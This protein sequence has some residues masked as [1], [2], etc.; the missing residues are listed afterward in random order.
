MPLGS[1]VVTGAGRLAHQALIHV[2]GFNPLWTA[3]GRSI[4]RSNR[5]AIAEAAQ[6]GFASIAVPA[7]GAG[8]ERLNT[9]RS[10][11]RIRH[12]L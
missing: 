5:N 11:E 7:I 9:T 2:P 4:R 6:L 10:L 8:S 3:T 12:E 1:A